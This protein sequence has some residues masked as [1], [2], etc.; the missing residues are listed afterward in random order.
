MKRVGLSIFV[1]LIFALSSGV[2]SSFAAEGSHMDMDGS[3]MEMGKADVAIDGYCPVCITK[4]K[5]MKGN[6][7][8]STEYKGKVYYF[9]G[10]DQQKMF[11]NDPEAYIQNLEKKFMD[12]KMQSEGSPKA[13]GSH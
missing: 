10:F 3:H 5:Y 8:F 9:P 12:L 4:G 13:E 1:A 2:V 7:K 6:P 11:V